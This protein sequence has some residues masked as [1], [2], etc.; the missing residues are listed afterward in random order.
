MSWK[1]WEKNSAGAKGQK[2]PG[3]KGLP[4]PVGRTMVVEKGEN[5][6]WVWRLKSVE[7]PTEGNKDCFDVRV[8]DTNAAAEKGISVKDYT[9]LDTAPD[10]ILYAGWYDKKSSQ[11]V[12]EKGGTPKR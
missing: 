11:A 10:L 4:N 1:F 2:L 5:P 8:F 9:S 3:P 12:L 7:R 6:D